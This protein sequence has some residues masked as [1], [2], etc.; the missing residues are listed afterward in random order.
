[1]SKL[2]SEGLKQLFQDF[3]L[4][5]NDQKD[6]LC[7]LDAK[8][9]DGDLG[10]TMSKGF[11][12]V[13]EIIAAMDEKDIGRILQQTGLILSEY[14]PSTMGTLLA[15]GFM[16]AGKNLRGYDQIDVKGLLI[17]IKTLNEGIMKRGKANPGGKTVVDVLDQ[18]LRFAE[19]N[20]GD[21]LASIL[22]SAE[23]GA[24]K[25]LE[26]TKSM[27]AMYGR[28]AIFREKTFGIQDP[29]GTVIWLLIKTFADFVS[30]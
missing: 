18:C 9:G 13:S 21:S 23:R 22:Q 20:N 19:K 1:M 16:E 15:S 28:A 5:I 30:G 2:D 29:G 10:I 8:I 12:K 25:G 3:S 24:S 7:E 27:M 26:D 17:F 4:V 6:H 14:A 11:S